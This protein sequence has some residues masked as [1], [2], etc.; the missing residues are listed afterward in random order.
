MQLKILCPKWGHEQLETEAFFIKVK[1]VGYD[2]VDTWMPEEKD[3]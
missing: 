3:H 2:G 1:E